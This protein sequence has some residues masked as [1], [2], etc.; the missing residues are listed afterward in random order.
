MW[1]GSTLDLVLWKNVFQGRLRKW[2]GDVWLAFWYFVFDYLCDCGG[3]PTSPSPFLNFFLNRFFHNIL[4]NKSQC[5]W[6]RSFSKTIENKPGPFL[7]VDLYFSTTL[8]PIGIRSNFFLLLTSHG[9]E[10][11]DSISL[12]FLNNP[13]MIAN[14]FFSSFKSGRKCWGTFCC[15]LVF[16]LT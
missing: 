3:Q 16:T 13:L 1:N 15:V 5:T 2:I 8:F 11:P 6:S 10:H 7:F 14:L 9:R 12:F 4:L